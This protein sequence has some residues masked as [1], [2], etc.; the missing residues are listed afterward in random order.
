MYWLLTAAALLLFAAALCAPLV[1][2]RG[3][4]IRRLS[5]DTAFL[6][7][8]GLALVM[9]R[10]PTIFGPEPYI[11]EAQMIAQAIT[12]AHHPVPWRSFDGT[13]SGPL[14]T[15]ALL[16]AQ[17]FGQGGSI[18][19]A[20]LVAL[21]LVAVTIGAVFVAVRAVFGPQIARVASVPPLMLFGFGANQDFV[22]YASETLPVM[23]LTVPLAITA[24]ATAGS[25]VRAGWVVVAGM[26]CGATP[27]AKLQAAPLTVVVV[28]T[29]VAVFA[30]RGRRASGATVFLGAVLAVP[31]AIVALVTAGGA[32]R[33]MWISYIAQ[34]AASMNGASATLDTAFSYP[35][36]RYYFIP[37]AAALALL[38]A[39]WMFF[40]QPEGTSDVA[41][42]RLRRRS[43][44]VA[45]ALLLASAYAIEAPHRAY[46]HYFLFAI[47]PLS[48]LV[49]A[50]AGALRAKLSARPRI[51]VD[52]VL[53]GYALAIAVPLLIRGAGERGGA[54]ADVRNAAQAPV[55]P[56]A[57]A[58]RA[59]D[60][61][62]GRVAIWGYA[63]YLYVKSGT[64]MGTR[65]A[66]AQFQNLPGPYREYYRARFLGD[67]EHN[68][69]ALFVDA[70]A[71][72]Q[73][74]FKS[75]S[76]FGLETLP[77]MAAYVGKHYALV[78]EVK[79]VRIYRLRA[80]RT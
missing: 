50:L 6:A 41:G 47:V 40:D 48:L 60:P 67:L 55:D 68:E 66:I 75:R 30:G 69:P 54:L 74:D 5:T 37:A 10:W 1:P 39:A 22:W 23:L 80:R 52:A 49:P 61:P 56:V 35:E 42:D 77:S 27:F 11:D 57:Q 33:D 19:G 44:L 21:V 70:C 12:A 20:R 46:P 2:Q 9:M 51:A 73:F 24:R 78:T 31:A 38:A 58:I 62:G 76:E 32:L 63:P 53:V 7:T 25:P 14:N 36:Y 34:G 79:G 28:A 15:Y 64:M 65:D 43:V 29:C 59:A 17:L 71:P 16:L 18:V 26:C 13:T 45:F 3:E 72:G 4:R 8:A